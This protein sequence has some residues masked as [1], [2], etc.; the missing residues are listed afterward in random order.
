MDKKSKKG[1]GVALIPGSATTV[2]SPDHP[3]LQDIE[4]IQPQA[5]NA[6]LTCHNDI[7]GLRYEDFPPSFIVKESW[8]LCIRSHEAEMYQAA[9]GLFGVPDLICSFNV[10]GPDGKEYSNSYVTPPDSTFWNIFHREGP[11]TEIIPEV[12]FRSRSV[13]ATEGRDLLDASSPK[14]LLQGIL[15]GMIGVSGH[16]VIGLAI[17]L[18]LR[19]LMF[20]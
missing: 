15:H 17:G 13:F 9:K 8:P 19:L 4:P 18:A 10:K 12:R 14:E 20:L 16:Q 2:D 3:L 7:P 6:H 1:K 5:E 11:S